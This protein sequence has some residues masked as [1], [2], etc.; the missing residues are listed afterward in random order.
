LTLLYGQIPPKL[1][2][3]LSTELRIDLKVL[4]V[5]VKMDRPEDARYGRLQ[6]V[7]RYIDQNYDVSTADQPSAWFRGELGLRSGLYGDQSSGM[8]LLTGLAGESL[9]VLIGS[10]HHL[11]GQRPA[12]GS[13][14]MTYSYLPALLGLIERDDAERTDRRRVTHPLYKS[15]VEPTDEIALRQVAQFVQ[16]VRGPSEPCEFLLIVRLVLCAQ[17]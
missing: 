3:R 6:V 16:R 1:L 5:S 13:I 9:I 4:A 2:S 14:P 11:T 12:P 7:E 10:A 17:I 8:L 15:P